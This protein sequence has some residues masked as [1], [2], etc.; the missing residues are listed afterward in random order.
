MRVA[1]VCLGHDLVLTQA[2][3]PAMLP[4]NVAI[5][6]FSLALGT[7]EGGIGENDSANP[8]TELTRRHGRGHPSHRMPQENWRR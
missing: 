6:N 8:M 1:R 5:V 4:G 2:E 7:E 3:K